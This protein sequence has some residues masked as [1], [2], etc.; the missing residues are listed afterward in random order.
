MIIIDQLLLR[1]LLYG[2]YDFVSSGDVDTLFGSDFYRCLLGRCQD[3]LVLVP[4]EGLGCVSTHDSVVTFIGVYSGDVK[5]VW[6][7]SSGGVGYVSTHFRLATFIRMV[8]F[9]FLGR[10]LE[11][12]ILVP[13]EMSG[14]FGLGDW[15]DVNMVRF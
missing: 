14:C 11:G 8:W 4:R 2:W 13:R 3:G 5:M 6:F 1:L 7:G 9:W 10:C 15:R 12:L